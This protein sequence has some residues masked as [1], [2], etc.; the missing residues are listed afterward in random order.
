MLYSISE[1]LDD[2]SNDQVRKTRD[3]FAYDLDNREDGS[4]CRN[5]L[6]FRRFNLKLKP[7]LLS[8]APSDGGIGLKLNDEE[9]DTLLKMVM[10]AHSR[11]ELCLMAKIGTAWA[12]ALTKT[13]SFFKS[14]YPYIPKADHS[15]PIAYYEKP[16]ELKSCIN[17]VTKVLK[18][19][20][21]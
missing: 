16:Q 14:Q 8:K 3:Q 18:L 20:Y 7:A 12:E 10:D 6:D 1:G 11:K 19:K 4:K 5:P 15:E 21:P 9:R 2:A 13:K 17:D